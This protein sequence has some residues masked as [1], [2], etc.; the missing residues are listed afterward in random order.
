LLLANEYRGFSDVSS[1]QQPGIGRLAHH[2]DAAHRFAV[3]TLGRHL[4][5]DLCANGNTRRRRVDHDG[6]DVALE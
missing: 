3:G 2:G 6:S 4:Q 5:R 1:M